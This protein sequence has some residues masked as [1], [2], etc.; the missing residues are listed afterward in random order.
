MPSRLSKNFTSNKSSLGKLPVEP[1]I[2]APQTLD[3]LPTHLYRL[4][5]QI[6]YH[7]VQDPEDAASMEDLAAMDKEIVALRDA[8]ATA[9]ANEKLLNANLVTLNATL[10]TEDLRAGVVALELDKQE[11]LARLGPLRSGSIKPVSMEE[12]EAVDKLWNEWSRKAR[13]R[14]QICLEVW[15]HC[16]EN[17][18]GEQTTGELWVG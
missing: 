8:I 11:I 7:A 6:V 4:G 3:R 14:K 9:K 17:L 10:S 5:K 12:K 1:E 18:Q 13:M 2:T 15:A 16:T